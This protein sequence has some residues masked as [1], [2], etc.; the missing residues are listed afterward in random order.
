MRSAPL[1][2]VNDPQII[3]SGLQPD[4]HTLFK[5]LWEKAANVRFYQG[6]VRRLT[7][8]ATM[9]AT[10][11]GARMRGLHQQQVSNGT[12]YVWSANAA[13]E[14][15]RWYGPA[16]ELISTE[17]GF[18]VDQSDTTP[19]SMVDFQ[20]WGN[21]TL[22]NAGGS[23]RRYRPGELTPLDNLPNAPTGVTA[24]MKKQNQLLAIGHGTNRK[25][26]SFSHAD[27]ITVWAPTT[28][29]LAGTL[30]IEELDTGIKA[31]TRLGPAIACYAEDQLAIVNWVGSPAYYGQR[32]AL[33]G[34]GAVGKYAVTAD[35][36]L[37]Y[38]VSR[39]GIWRTDG[40]EYQY[41]DE[42]RLSEYLQANVNWDQASKIIAFRNDVSRCIEFHFP[43]GANLEVSEAWSFDP[44]TGGWGPVTSYQAAMGRVLFDKP[45]AASGGTVV[46]LDDNPAVAA[47]LY[48]ETKPL[49]IESPNRAGLH[50]DA[51]VDEVEL[52]AKSATGVQFR[53][54]VATDVDGPYD[55]TLW[56]DINPDLRTYRLGALPS[57]TFFKLAIRSTIDNWD[58]D[59]QGFAFYGNAE[60]VKRDRL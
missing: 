18:V 57:G 25:Q 4:R 41:I 20:T 42:G 7:P 9:F 19:A 10:T 59:L 2:V 1:L 47:P 45:I 52:A 39:N 35:G 46:L 51:R 22:F 12:R 34:I 28:T 38:G 49:M 27:D 37:N 6:K 29:N 15:H 13:G 53:V 21:W 26:V 43:M 32:V 16:A 36:R 8:A 55:K 14:I 50:M 5:P 58:L 23:I 33:D 17:A 56:E 44:A 30:P 11:A 48:L 60:G 54:M 3:S 40:N 31:A 24:I